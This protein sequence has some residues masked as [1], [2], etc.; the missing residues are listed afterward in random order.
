VVKM[1]SV[2]S[3]EMVFGVKLLHYTKTGKQ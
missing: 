1:L 2:K 3:I